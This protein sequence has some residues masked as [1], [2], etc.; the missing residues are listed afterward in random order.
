LLLVF[1]C[2]IKEIRTEQMTCDNV[3]TKHQ[4][5]GVVDV[6]LID[7]VL[8]AEPFLTPQRGVF[9]ANE[10]LMQ[11]WTNH[12][13]GRLPHALTTHAGDIGPAWKAVASKFMLHT[14]ENEPSD[15]V[16]RRQIQL[17]LKLYHAS[18]GAF[19]PCFFN[20]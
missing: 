4:N 12:Q 9:K 6:S 18:R 10:M 16:D 14:H 7:D 1:Y 3:A 20:S 17:Q 11:D 5:M 19:S 2:K 15:M 13:E 8:E